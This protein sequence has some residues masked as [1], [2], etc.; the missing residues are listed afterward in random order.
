EPEAHNA[1]HG[2]VRWANWSVVDRAADRVRMRYVV[3]PQPGWPGTLEISIAYALTDSGIA[4]QTTATNIGSRSCPYG[5]GQHPY[6]TL[7]TDTIDSLVLQSPGRRYLESDERG[8]PVASH[9]VAGTRFDYTEPRELGP[10]KLDAGYT[11]L[12]RDADGYAR[13]QVHSVDGTR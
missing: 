5:A 6:L 1:I 13:V 7:G 12:D 8:I 10:D 9:P 3:H 2:L 4:V 11:D